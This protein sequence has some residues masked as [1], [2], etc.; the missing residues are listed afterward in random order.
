MKWL[1]KL[2]CKIGCHDWRE[3]NG[4]CCECGYVDPLWP[5]LTGGDHDGHD[6]DA[7]RRRTGASGGP[8]THSEFLRSQQKR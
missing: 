8:I 6:H 4:V 1:S 5:M 7:E 3:M 2:L